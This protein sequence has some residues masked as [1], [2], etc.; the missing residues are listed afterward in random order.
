MSGGYVKWNNV[1][2]EDKALIEEAKRFIQSDTHLSDEIKKRSLQVVLLENMAR[3]NFYKSTSGGMQG[4]KMYFEDI[5]KGCAS[6]YELA[7]NLRNKS[8]S[9]F[10]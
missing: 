4:S 3:T 1:Q 10:R 2:A 9:A 8:W 7:E 6:S 5:A